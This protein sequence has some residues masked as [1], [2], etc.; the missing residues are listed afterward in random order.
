MR[1]EF[2]CFTRSGR[3]LAQYLADELARRGN[4]TRVTRCGEANATVAE[5]ARENFPV[6]DAL[7]FVGALGIAVRAI[8]PHLESKT[9]D[10]A[11]VTLDD[12]GT[13]AISVL[14]G[15]LGGAN[16]LARELASLTGATPVVTTST[17]LNGVFAVDVWA[18]RR[19]LAIVNPSSIKTVSAKLLNGDTVRVRC[20][21]PVSGELPPGLILTDDATDLAI[22]VRDADADD[23]LKLVPKAVVLGIGCRRGVSADEIEEAFGEFSTEHRLFPEAFY[24]ARS[25]DL[26]RYEP[27][28]IDF[29]RKFGLEFSVFTGAQLAAVPGKFAASPF[30]EETTGVDNVCERSAVLGA[31]GELLAGKTVFSGIALA[32]AARPYVI[33]FS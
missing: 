7:V 3:E 20:G 22:D 25:I 24:A 10:P 4:A 32:A 5:W 23:V 21:F 28:V 14:S 31:G 9:T 11:V 12:A 8:A 33:D 6:A 16:Q 26:K 13:F 1:I 17:D 29:C 18:A 2:A 27:G 19:Q 30:V 15:H